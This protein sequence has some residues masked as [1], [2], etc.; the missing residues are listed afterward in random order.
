[1][2]TKAIFE[3]IFKKDIRDENNYLF[4]QQVAQEHPYFSAAQFFLLLQTKKNTED[5]KQQAAKTAL[6]FNNPFG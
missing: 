3:S 2:T 6:Y 5:F 1:M 4:L